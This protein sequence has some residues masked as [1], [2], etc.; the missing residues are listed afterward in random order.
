M[1][2]CVHFKVNRDKELNFTFWTYVNCCLNRL[3]EQD[4]DLLNS[5]NIEGQQE[6]TQVKLQ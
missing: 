4:E 1:G 2:F 3:F 6:Q 5:Y